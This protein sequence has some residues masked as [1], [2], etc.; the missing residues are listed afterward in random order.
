MPQ[1]LEILKILPQTNCGECG[2]PTCLAF[3]FALATGATSAEKCPALKGRKLPWDLS[4][5]KP[6]PEEDFAWKILEEVQKKAQGIDWA[7]RAPR[8]GLEPA[9]LGWRVPYLDTLVFLSPE[10]ASRQDGLELDPRD[11]ILLYNYVIFGGQGPLSG[12]YVGLEAFPHSLSKVA[13]LR[14]YAETRLAEAFTGRLAALKKA[15]QAFICTYPP[16]SPADL[17]VIVWV[18][19]KVPLRIHFFEGDPEEGLGAEVKILFDQ[20]ATVYLDLE[21]LVFCAERLVERLEELAPA[22]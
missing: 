22:T 20:K 18:L 19:P 11:Q 15:L 5:T 9:P 2:Y 10:R 16:D 6:V 7:E 4:E 8:L 21:S 1:P 17:G 13:T 12:E 3:A 14:R